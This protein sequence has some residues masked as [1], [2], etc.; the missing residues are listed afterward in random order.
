MLVHLQGSTG[1]HPY[2]HV[3]LAFLTICFYWVAIE[4]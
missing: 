1:R 4:R 3:K 2:Q